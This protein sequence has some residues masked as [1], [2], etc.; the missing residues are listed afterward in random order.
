MPRVTSIDL[1]SYELPADRIAQEPREERDRSRALFLRRG[2]E[3]IDEGLFRELPA[4]LR[5][6]ECLVI[7][8]TRVI[9]ARVRARRSTGGEIEAFLLRPEGEGI[10]RAW[11]SPSRRLQPGEELATAG[12]PLRLL[13]REGR[14]WRVLLPEGELGRIGEIPLPPYIRRERGDAR[15]SGLDRERY[16]TVFARRE[17]AVAAPTAGLHFT[18]EILAAIAARGVPVVPVTLHVGPGTFAPVAVERIEEHRVDPELFEVSAASRA[19]LA[20]ARKEGRR[21]VCVG[22]TSIRVLESLPDLSPGDRV[23]G[24]CSLTI[25]PGHRFRHAAGL[26]TNFH[27]PRSSLLVLVSAFHGRERTLAAYRAAIERGFRFYS[28]GDAMAILPAEDSSC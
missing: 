16:Q 27:L 8:D 1:Y 6:D 26:I 15:L 3:A 24:E 23:C 11:L 17:G 13:S 28:Y 19:A 22:T 10:W 18:P 25:L 5:G 20:A 4:R 7:N 14:W 2:E 21:F 9:P 12:A